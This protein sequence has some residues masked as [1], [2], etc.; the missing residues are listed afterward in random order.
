MKHESI[1]N[2]IKFIPDING[3]VMSLAEGGDLNSFL[4]GLSQP[5]GNS[6]CISHFC[7][8]GWITRLKWALQIG[9]ALFFIH[10]RG[11]VHSNIILD[12]K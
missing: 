1:I 8:V 11:V 2:Y 5:V 12:Y 4:V 3:I 9:E 7:G 6:N 10:E